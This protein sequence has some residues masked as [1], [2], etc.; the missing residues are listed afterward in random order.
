M[1]WPCDPWGQYWVMVA[2]NSGCEYYR[3]CGRRTTVG[4]ARTHQRIAPA[5]AG[6]HTPRPADGAG[7]KTALLQQ[8]TAVVGR[9]SA[10]TLPRWITRYGVPAPVRN[11]A[12]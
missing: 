6:A 5:N 4:K 12:L 2:F 10:T 7:G 3:P 8:A 11:C 9:A 1:K